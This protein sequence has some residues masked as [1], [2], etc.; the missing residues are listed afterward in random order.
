MGTAGDKSRLLVAALDGRT[1]KYTGGWNRE[2]VVGGHSSKNIPW[3]GIATDLAIAA[4]THDQQTFNVAH[5]AIQ[6]YMDQ[7]IGKQH[8]PFTGE[9]FSTTYARWIMIPMHVCA[10]ILKR[11]HDEIHRDTAGDL[12]DMLYAI[13]FFAVMSAGGFRKFKCSPVSKNPGKLV[14]EVI[15]ATLWGGAR[16][17][18]SGKKNGSRR[19]KG[20]WRQ[21]QWADGTP[22]NSWLYHAIFTLDM[23]RVQGDN[24][25]ISD[26]YKAMYRMLMAD[27]V[28]FN[29]VQRRFLQQCLNPIPG[30]FE[31]PGFRKQLEDFQDYTPRDASIYIVRAGV[32]AVTLWDKTFHDGST[33]TMVAKWYDDNFQFH[34]YGPA[35]P[36]RRNKFKAWVS[37]KWM[38]QRLVAS[39]SQYDYDE[40]PWDRQQKP[41]MKVDSL[42]DGMRVDVMTLPLNIDEQKVY[43]ILHITPDGVKMGEMLHIPEVPDDTDDEPNWDEE[44]VLGWL[45]K[46]LE[47]LQKVLDRRQ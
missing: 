47:W 40:G 12:F 32:Q 10:E 27:T 43:S 46:G 16:S 21:I 9:E 33:G 20:K 29:V 44:D 23:R 28:P 39:V 30:F 8:G 38:N 42:D 35:E 11:S 13:A 7:V 2:N 26:V 5:D 14:Q 37:F 22:M 34:A 4:R 25:W 15:P 31:T 17:W 6:G 41:M 36:K 3:L 18:A 24:N 1:H 45:N 19:E